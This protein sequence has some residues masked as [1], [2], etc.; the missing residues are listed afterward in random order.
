MLSLRIPERFPD[1]GGPCRCLFR[2]HSSFFWLRSGH[3]LFLPPP[4]NWESQSLT[5]SCFGLCLP[6][7]SSSQATNPL[8]AEPLLAPFPWESRSESAGGW[9][10]ALASQ[11]WTDL[12]PQLSHPTRLGGCLWG[13]PRDA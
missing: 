4:T 13:R 1:V 3:P 8:D 2:A 11:V 10:E 12:L 9:L 5:M 7:K 6:K